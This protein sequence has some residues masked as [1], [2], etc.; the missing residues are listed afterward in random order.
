MASGTGLMASALDVTSEVSLY[1][2]AFDFDTPFGRCVAV[3]LLPA[4]AADRIAIISRLHPDEQALCHRMRGA[5]LVEFA[6]GR[7]AAALA[8]MDSTARGKPTLRGPGGMPTVAGGISISISHTRRLAVA[9]AGS[10]AG[11]VGVD[12]EPFDDDDPHGHLAGRILSKAERH[13][14]A[15]GDAIPIGWRLSLKEAAYKALFP[16]LGHVPLRS[17]GVGRRHDGG[18]GF[19]IA[20]PTGI[21][22]VAD[23][24][25]I[26]GHVLSLATDARTAGAGLPT[27]R[28]CGGSSPE[29]EHPA[30]RKTVLSPKRLVI[31]ST[32]GD[33]A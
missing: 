32:S 11:P 30:A 6:G 17:I 9:L 3:D 33:C 4:A 19:V 12:I 21:S 10:R 26:V 15:A 14:D 27:P 22:V 8:L 13:A 23:A 18:P 1:P 7:I 5:R 25:P 20:A 29:M 24:R 2:V 31:A 28:R 16:R